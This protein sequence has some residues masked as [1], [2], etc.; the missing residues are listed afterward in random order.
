M[1]QLTVLASLVLAIL[2]GCATRPLPSEIYQGYPGPELPDA[3]VATVK[4][5]YGFG[6]CADVIDF[7]HPDCSKY[8]S[9]KLAPGAHHIKW[10]R[11]FG[12]S[13]M[14]DP[15]MQATYSGNAQ[16]E[17]EAG[18]TYAL[19]S[20]RTYGMGYRVFFWIEDTHTGSVIWGTKKL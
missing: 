14:V 6:T 17:L 20:D 11:T 8:G 1:K 19:R 13:V 9:I 5:A 4:W 18:H 16:V 10:S 3:S 12:V 7:A 2:A 15:R